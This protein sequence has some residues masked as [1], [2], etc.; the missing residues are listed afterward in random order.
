[1]IFVYVELREE[2]LEDENKWVCV[3][4]WEGGGGEVGS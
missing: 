4:R 2:V 3:R 1:M